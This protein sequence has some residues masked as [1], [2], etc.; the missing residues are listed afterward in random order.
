MIRVGRIKYLNGGRD[1]PDYEGFKPI[2]VMTKSSQYGSLGPYVLKDKFGRIMENI[3]QFS[4]VYEKVPLARETYSRYD[5]RVIWEHGAEK[6]YNTDTCKLS[7]EY[8]LWRKKGF[9]CDD[10]VRYP[11]GFNHR[12]NCLFSLKNYKKPL[13]K[14]DYIESRKKIY[15]PKY[16][17]LV[18]RQSQYKDLLIL[19]E[20][21]Q[22]LLILEVDGPHQ[23]SLKYYKDKYKVKD[24]FIE[25]DTILITKKTMEIM[26]NDDKH[27]FGHGYCLAMTLLGKD[28]K[29]I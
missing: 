22:N 15:L 5:N 1:I 8:S 12:H 20:A 10:P 17:Q 23:E 9:N 21:G 29:W 14:L 13:D 24:N 6:H 25:R 27:P 7:K 26:L 3:W 28:K 19:L 18:K 16:S 4:K 11:V 2:V